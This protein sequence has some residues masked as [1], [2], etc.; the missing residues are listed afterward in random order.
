MGKSD[1]RPEFCIDKATD[2]VTV[3]PNKR[4]EQA[5]HCF[6]LD[7]CV[8]VPE[9]VKRAVEGPYGHQLRIL[10]QSSD[11]LNR[12]GESIKSVGQGAV[13]QIMNQCRKPRDTIDHVPVGLINPREIDGFSFL[14]GLKRY[15][16]CWFL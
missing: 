2:P 10:K 13:A 3:S 11:D 16:A 1:P 7:L 6:V 9:G 15:D 14:G 8:I 5:G 12:R 4:E